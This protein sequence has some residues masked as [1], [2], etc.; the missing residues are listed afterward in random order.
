M[1]NTPVLPFLIAHAHVIAGVV[2]I[3]VGVLVMTQRVPIGLWLAK[4]PPSDEV[5]SA[6]MIVEDV[7]KRFG[8]WSGPLK[9][10]EAQRSL[11]NVFPQATTKQ[12][13]LL[14]ELA[15]NK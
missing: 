14:I 5:E 1:I 10:R 13:N 3:L 2:V 15:L 8:T 9:A 11:L 4:I 6:R 12:L 7:E